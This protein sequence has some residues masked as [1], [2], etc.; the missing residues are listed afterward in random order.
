LRR[1]H[2]EVAWRPH[3]VVGYAAATCANTLPP[4]Q[5]GQSRH[6]G[7]DKFAHDGLPS[8]NGDLHLGHVL[9]DLKDVIN[10]AQQMFHQA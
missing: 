3:H 4:A 7:R 1:P 2:D 5:P 8:A 9:T 10:R 6:L